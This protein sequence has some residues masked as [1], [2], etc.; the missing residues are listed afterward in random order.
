VCNVTGNGEDSLGRP[1][2]AA[3]V[4]AHPAHALKLY[5]WLLAHRP[6][7][8]FLT[9][10][11]GTGPL[12]AAHAESLMQDIERI[13]GTR[14]GIFTDFTDAGIFRAILRGDAAYFTR[15]VDRLAASFVRNEIT[16]VVADA[17]EGCS[18][19]HDLCRAMTDAAVAM[20]ERRLGWTI[21]N[22]GCYQTEWWSPPLHD[23]ACRH[24]VLDDVVFARKLEAAQQYPEWSGL[25]REATGSMGFEYFRTECLRPVLDTA[26]PDYATRPFYE[27]AGEQQVAIGRFE[28]VIRYEAHIRPIW[29]AIRAHAATAKCEDADQ[30]L[31]RST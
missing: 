30:S 3:L 17:M 14:G 12:G 18:P 31:A 9:N 24:T 2:R 10:G 21:A 11:A 26:P 23:A 7:A 29:N 27:I 22:F 28:T 19:A 5:G 25:I 16:L 15:I 1:A 4:V 6:V 13:G 8:H 20:A